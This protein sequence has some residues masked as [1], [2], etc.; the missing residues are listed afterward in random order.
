MI[1]R[2]RHIY[3]CYDYKNDERLKNTVI[4]YTNSGTSLLKVTDYSQAQRLGQKDWE[5][6]MKTRFAVLDAVVILLG[7]QTYRAPN[8][9]EE[10]EIAYKLEL[11]IVQFNISRHGTRRGL[12]NGGSIVKWDWEILQK[13]ILIMVPY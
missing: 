8:V 10:T 6:N 7:E 3:L 4:E 9:I 2:K 12:V 11:P 1:K 13:K 5:E